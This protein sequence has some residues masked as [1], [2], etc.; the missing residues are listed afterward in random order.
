M[1]DKR[2]YAGNIVVNGQECDEDTLQFIRAN[3]GD[4]PVRVHLKVTRYTK[5]IDMS[6]KSHISIDK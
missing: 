2:A 1:C 4:V 3:A 5:D 6:G